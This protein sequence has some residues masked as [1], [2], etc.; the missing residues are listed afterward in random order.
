MYILQSGNVTFLSQYVNCDNDDI[1]LVS[2][3]THADAR[4]L[5]EGHIVHI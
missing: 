1:I 2:P 3:S 5:T 4:A